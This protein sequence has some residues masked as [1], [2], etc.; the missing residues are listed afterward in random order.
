MNAEIKKTII[1]LGK[2]TLKALA[3]Y[4]LKVPYADRIE[5]YSFIYI[6]SEKIK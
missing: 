4:V 2:E 3:E 6:K 1:V 5:T